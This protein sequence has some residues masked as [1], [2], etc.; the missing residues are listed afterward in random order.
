MTERYMKAVSLMAEKRMRQSAIDLEVKD[1][2]EHERA[3]NVIQQI[4][5]Y[6][7]ISRDTGAGAS[8]LGQRLGQRLGWEVLNKEMLERMADR[9][10]LDKSMV[11]VVDEAPAS[12]MLEVFGKWISQRVVTQ[13]EFISRLGKVVMTAAREGS[14]IFV[15]RGAQYFLP[16]E[17]GLAVQLIAPLKMRLERVMRREGLDADAARRYLQQKDRERREFVRRNFGCEVTDQRLYD[18]VVNLE[19]LAMDDAVDFIASVVEKRFGD[20]ML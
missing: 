2:M 9:Y 4:K 8:E 14:T 5:P 13:S 12:W 3:V 17:R 16:R 18:L 1:L 11:E 15:G 20:E 7:A 10:H 6:L 19:H